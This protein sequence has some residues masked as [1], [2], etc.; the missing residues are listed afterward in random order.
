MSFSICLPSTST[1]FSKSLL[2]SSDLKVAPSTT[3]V[4]H[5]PRSKK[6]SMRFTVILFKILI[7]FN[8]SQNHIFKLKIFNVCVE[9]ILHT[10]LFYEKLST[11][12]RGSRLDLLVFALIV[13]F[14]VLLNFKF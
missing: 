12:F 6:K 13:N 5:R 3:S 7:T 9:V 1:K 2:V 14:P 4:D 11:F 10:L 8:L